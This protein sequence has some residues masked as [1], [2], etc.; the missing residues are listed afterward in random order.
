MKYTLILLLSIWSLISWGQLNVSGVANSY[1]A[2]SSID[3]QT[4]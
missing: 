1:Y 3:N 4:V 2:I